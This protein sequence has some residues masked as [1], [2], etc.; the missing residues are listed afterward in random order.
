MAHGRYGYDNA[1]YEREQVRTTTTETVSRELPHGPQ[2]VAG[3]TVPDNVTLIPNRVGD[4]DRD[5]AVKWLDD[6]HVAGLIE[7]DELEVRRAHL[8]AAKTREEV[9]M[10]ISDLGTPPAPKRQPKPEEPAKTLRHRLSENS[11]G[12]AVGCLLLAFIS[13]CMIILPWVLLSGRHN[14]VTAL[15]YAGASALCMAGV[16][17]AVGTLIWATT[18]FDWD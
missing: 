12:V 2:V 15:M 11:P 8:L 5:R 16:L 3:A 17:T 10:L 14:P 6:R 4:A 18:A 7:A 9:A 13:L 1:G